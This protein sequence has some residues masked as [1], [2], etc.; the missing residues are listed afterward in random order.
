MYLLIIMSHTTPLHAACGI[1]TIE[2][3]TQWLPQAECFRPN[4]RS[5]AQNLFFNKLFVN[6]QFIKMGGNI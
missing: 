4:L 2:P 6:V 3:A 5:L 1:E